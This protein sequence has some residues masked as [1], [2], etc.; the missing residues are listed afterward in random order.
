MLIAA[1]VEPWNRQSRPVNEGF[2]TRLVGVTKDRVDGLLPASVVAA[3]LRMTI[4]TR[5]ILAAFLPQQLQR[6]ALGG[7][8]VVDLGPLRQQSGRR[9]R[10]CQR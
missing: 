7:Q 1:A 6:H 5:I 4:A 8:L 3:E 2:F 10:T 9:L